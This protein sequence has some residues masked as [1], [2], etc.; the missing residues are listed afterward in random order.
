MKT[1]ETEAKKVLEATGKSRNKTWKATEEVSKR[2]ELLY[3]LE[4][5]IK[6][7]DINNI[8]NLS[9]ASM[10]QYIHYYFQKMIFN[11]TKTK[12]ADLETIM[13][14]LIVEYYEKFKATTDVTTAMSV[15]AE[16]SEEFSSGI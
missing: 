10:H 3:W 14:P 16:D 7:N 15:S 8:L 5:E 2:N 4:G 6:N 13:S 9:G 11:L 12:K 1:K